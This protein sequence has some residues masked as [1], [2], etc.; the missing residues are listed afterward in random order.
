MQ[1]V[2]FKPSHEHS[3]LL[4]LHSYV[5]FDRKQ[6][7]PSVTK[8]FTSSPQSIKNSKGPTSTTVHCSTTMASYE[9]VVVS[10]DELWKMNTPSTDEMPLSGENGTN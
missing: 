4:H 6:L 3:T 10:S 7:K 5:M 1:V 2:R 9:A 8:D